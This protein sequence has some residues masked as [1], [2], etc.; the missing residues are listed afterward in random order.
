MKILFRSFWFKYWL[1]RFQW[2]RRWYGGRWEHH[3][4]DICDCAMWLDMHHD[5]KWPEW[6]QPCSSG[7]PIIEDYP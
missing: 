3:W 6:V 1:C 4:I 7:I 2:Y 5:R